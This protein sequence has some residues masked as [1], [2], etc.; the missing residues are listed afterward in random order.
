MD[1]FRCNGCNDVFSQAEAGERSETERTEAWGQRAVI[2]PFYLTCPQCGR[3]EIEHHEKCQTD[4]CLTEVVGD[5]LEDCAACF[6][7][8]DL[9]GFMEYIHAARSISW[10]APRLQTR[11]VAGGAK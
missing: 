11:Q 4:G 10:I 3:D 2:T 9:E 8:A 1:Y 7:E 5:G 6:A